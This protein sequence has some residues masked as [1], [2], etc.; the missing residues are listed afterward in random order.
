[1]EGLGFD[2]LHSQKKKKKTKYYNEVMR[3][4]T[5]FHNEAQVERYFGFDLIIFQIKSHNI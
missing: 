5:D 2:P 3:L 4:R 1:V